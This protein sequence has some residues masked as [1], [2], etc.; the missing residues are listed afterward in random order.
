[1]AAT[2]LKTKKKDFYK[3]F[4]DAVIDLP[5]Y[6]QRTK[7]RRRFYRRGPVLQRRHWGW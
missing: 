1:M 2:A 4:F 3:N 5:D 6:W 7:H